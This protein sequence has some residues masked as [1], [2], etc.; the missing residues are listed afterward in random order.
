MEHKNKPMG[1]PPGP[2]EAQSPK[3]NK[4]NKE[5]KAEYL[6]FLNK[7]SSEGLGYAIWQYPPDFAKLALYDNILTV[8]LQTLHNLYTEI[9]DKIDLDMENEGIA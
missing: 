4:R 9:Q 6:D 8:K 5:G 1:K 3:G 2:P 7:V